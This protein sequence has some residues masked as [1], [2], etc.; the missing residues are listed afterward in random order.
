M[1]KRGYSL[2]LRCRA[3]RKHLVLPFAPIAISAWR[4]Q[5]ILEPGLTDGNL[6]R[7]RRSRMP[8]A[9]V[10]EHLTRQTVC[11]A[12][13]QPDCKLLLL[14]MRCSLSR[15]AQLCIPFHMRSFS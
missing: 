3:N 9:C 11:A 13:T 2:T 8:S 14:L 4:L 6:V 7:G 10:S 5:L 12:R 1:Y 15:E